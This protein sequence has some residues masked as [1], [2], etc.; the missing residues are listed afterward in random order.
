[1]SLGIRRRVSVGEEKKRGCISWHRRG[2]KR[3]LIGLSRL[4]KVREKVGRES[5]R[6]SWKFR[7]S[8]R[9]DRQILK[10]EVFH[11]SIYNY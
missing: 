10:D 11:T 1:M 7:K 2:V 5:R 4:I 8:T 9:N 3:D 6:V